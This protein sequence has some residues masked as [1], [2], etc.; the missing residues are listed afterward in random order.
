MRFGG[1]DFYENFKLIKLHLMYFVNY[2]Y[3]SVDYVALLIQI[4][5]KKSYELIML[6]K[7]NGSVMKKRI[8]FPMCISYFQG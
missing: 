2:S 6:N 8:I 5:L 3:Y 4:L 1:C 7:L